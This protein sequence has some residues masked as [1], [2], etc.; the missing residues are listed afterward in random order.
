MSHSA[1]EPKRSQ[2]CHFEPG[3]LLGNIKLQCINKSCS[4]QL[5]LGQPKVPRST[6]GCRGG[7][8]AIFGFHI[9]TSSGFMDRPRGFLER[10]DNRRKLGNVIKRDVWILA[11]A[12]HLLETTGM[13][14][15]DIIHCNKL[16]N[17][18]PL[19][20]TMLGFVHI[21]EVMGDSIWTANISLQ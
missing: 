18:F 14:D 17:R 13:A 20:G 7:N 1:E 4:H 6:G 12:V 11:L 15:S 9:S 8:R 3:L 19:G 10:H 16:L 5:I 21:I 2:L